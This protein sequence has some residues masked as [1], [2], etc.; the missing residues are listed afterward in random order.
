MSDQPVQPNLDAC[1]TLQLTEVRQTL[2]TA[3]RSF[4]T[5]PQLRRALLHSIGAIDDR[6]GR[7]REWPARRVRRGQGR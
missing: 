5:D 6:L 2:D 3:L 7:P 4:G 1:A